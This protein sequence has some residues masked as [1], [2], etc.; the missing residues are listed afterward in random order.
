MITKAL[1][2]EE[3]EEGKNRERERERRKKKEYIRIVHNIYVNLFSY[4]P[5][6]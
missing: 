4:F 6:A 1:E 3:E 2:E 5:D